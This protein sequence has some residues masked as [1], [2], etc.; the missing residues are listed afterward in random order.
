MR[1][2]IRIVTVFLL[3]I[4]LWSGAQELEVKSF[5]FSPTDIIP[6]NEQ[7]KDLNGT[8]CALVKIQ[9]V[10]DIDRVEGNIIG[11]IV[12]RGV[13]KWVYMT[14]GT[15]E[16]RLYPK[17]HLPLSISCNAYGIDGLESKRVYILRL[18][19]SDDEKN[20]ESKKEEQADARRQQTET[21]RDQPSDY[22]DSYYQQPSR[23][24]KTSSGSD[25]EFHV[26]AGLGFNTLSAMGPSVHFGAS[27]G[28]FSLEGG[29]VYGLDKVEDIH[30]SISSTVS[31]A[32]DYSCSKA[33]VKLGVNF[34]VEQFRISPQGGVTFNMISGKDA[35]NA[36]NTTDYFKESNPMS[37]FAAVRL[38]YEVVEHLRIHL[39]PQ[40]D[41]AIGGDQIFEVIK[42]GDSK[43]KAW[44][45]GF[46]INA[47]IIYEF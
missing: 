28:M 33:W 8:Y 20:E 11:D 35:G 1:I 47:G 24:K 13:E 7:R 15:K 6:A 5:V 30:L 32:W 45:E 43:I 9:I 42:K 46:G 37:A 27:Y 10:D 18:T 16:F 17:S 29:F 41:F 31:E 25:A 26:Y 3:M 38:S 40:Y 4:P 22:H 39:T 2:S 34:D 36:S 12:N 14:D 23:S 44:G 21:H 19:G